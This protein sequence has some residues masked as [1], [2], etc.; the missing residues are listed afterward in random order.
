MWLIA[1]CFFRGGGAAVGIMV[2]S[3]CLATFALVN[4][5]TSCITTYMSITTQRPDIVSF[6]DLAASSIY[7]MVVATGSSAEFNFLVR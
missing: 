1:G 3:W 4:I 2:T 7:Q 6:H 5:Y